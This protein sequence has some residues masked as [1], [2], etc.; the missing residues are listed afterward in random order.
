[1]TKPL[2]FSHDTG[3]RNDIKLQ[4]LKQ[5]MGFEGLGIYWCLLEIL[6]DNNGKLS[7]ADVDVYAYSLQADPEKLLQVLN[8]FGLF[9][10]Q[11]GEYYSE[12][13]N[14]RLG[15]MNEKSKKAKQAAAA[16]WTKKESVNFKEIQK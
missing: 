2:Y 15:K 1:M 9:V 14:K 5:V 10:K 13:A 11:S 4:R 16:R 12:S 8:K 3:A 7:H 6:Y